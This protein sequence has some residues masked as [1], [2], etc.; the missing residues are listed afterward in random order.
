MQRI[1]AHTHKNTHTLEKV[2]C[3]QQKSCFRRALSQQACLEWILSLQIS[4]KYSNEEKIWSEVPKLPEITAQ[5]LSEYK[6]HKIN[7]K[8]FIK[9]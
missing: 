3:K 2:T 5:T 7:F 8:K 6:H 1:Y 9:I 4:L